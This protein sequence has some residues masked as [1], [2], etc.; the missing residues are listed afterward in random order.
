MVTQDNLTTGEESSFE[1]L[2]LITISSLIL[3][4][5]DHNKTAKQLDNDVILRELQRQDKVYLDKIIENQ[6]KIL[7]ILSEIQKDMSVK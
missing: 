2:D 1:I 5:I 6:N 4:I 7:S 3:Q